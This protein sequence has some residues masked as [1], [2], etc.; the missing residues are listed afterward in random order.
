MALWNTMLKMGQGLAKA[1]KTSTA[2][3]TAQDILAEGKGP[4]ATAG[5]KGSLTITP[6]KSQTVTSGGD[7]GFSLS[8]TPQTKPIVGGDSGFFLQKTQQS[9]P[10]TGTK[11]SDGV[12]QTDWS[13][14]IREELD[15]GEQADA[16]LL[17]GYLDARNQKIT[18]DP[19]LAVYANDDIAKAARE[20]I[21]SLTKPQ[22]QEFDSS[23]YTAAQQAQDAYWKAQLKQ[24]V[25]GLEAQKGSVTDSAEEAARQAYISYMQSQNALPQALAASGY[26]GG[27]ADSQRLALDTNLQ[28]S[29][30]AILKSR[31]AALND[32]DTAVNNAR[33]ENSVQGAQ[34][35]VDL[36]RDAI[37]AYQNFL[38]QQN[39]YANQDFWTRYGYDFQAAQDAI[40]REYQTN[41]LLQQQQWQAQQGK[42]DTAQAVQTEAQRQAYESA[43]NLISAGVM[44]SVET[45]TMAGINQADAQAYV[46]Y[47]K[48][49]LA[50]QNQQRQSS[51]RITQDLNPWGTGDQGGDTGTGATGTPAS[52]QQMQDFKN[53]LVV[54]NR[55]GQSVQPVFNS[56]VKRTSK[57]QQE[58]I[59][60]YMK[61]LGWNVLEEE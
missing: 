48:S 35:Q 44:P 47:I 27:L 53:A 17:Q 37:A 55:M 6:A 10:V 7:K 41:T 50:A 12:G 8:A 33:L 11:Y 16:G 46:A 42:D 56:I 52:E 15:K 29:Q 32:I 24:T 1:V 20:R 2:G 30:Q 14:L 49:Q 21:A 5:S 43:W 38:N 22:Y 40:N 54:A 60:A 19:S 59:I 23:P 39:A 45:L 13:K 61:S 51:Y 3:K 26:A 25:A 31:D 4:R 18:S 9:T 34:A 36:A 28:N 58:D 57:E